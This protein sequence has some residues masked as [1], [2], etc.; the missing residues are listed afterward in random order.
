MS[1]CRISANVPQPP[2]RRKSPRA[3]SEEE[4]SGKRKIFFSAFF[5]VP[6]APHGCTPVISSFGGSKGATGACKEKEE[7]GGGGDYGGR[8]GSNDFSRGTRFRARGRDAGGEQPRGLCFTETIIPRL[9]SL[10][11][12]FSEIRCHD[13]GLNS[14]KIGQHNRRVFV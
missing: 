4:V 6:P 1:F 9:T 12:L 2:Q 13:T 11:L 5:L 3:K 7:G 8:R 10:G 14:P